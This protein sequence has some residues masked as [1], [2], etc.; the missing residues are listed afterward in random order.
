MYRISREVVIKHG[1]DL[2]E[3]VVEYIEEKKK[4]QEEEDF[5]LMHYLPC[6]ADP[7]P[8]KRPGD[9]TLAQSRIHPVSSSRK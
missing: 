7:N 6:Y 2:Q 4:Q 5:P 3:A 9:P 8:S 1:S